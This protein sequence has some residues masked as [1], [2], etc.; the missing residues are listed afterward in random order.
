M[1]ESTVRLECDGC[2]A[3]RQALPG[4]TYPQLRT[5]LRRVGWYCVGKVDLCPR[6]RIDPALRK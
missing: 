2:K 1:S 3:E 4:V 5:L 6:C